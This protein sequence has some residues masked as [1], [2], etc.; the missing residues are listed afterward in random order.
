MAL[1]RPFGLARCRLLRAALRLPRRL[2]SLTSTGFPE[3]APASP[4]VGCAAIE[5]RSQAA[6]P[7]E[8]PVRHPDAR[9]RTRVGPV[10]GSRPS[11]YPAR[12]QS[13]RKMQW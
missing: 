12:P 11:R 1:A 2:R 7:T 13:G 9:L 10:S 5:L 6:P 8:L 3:I 4:G